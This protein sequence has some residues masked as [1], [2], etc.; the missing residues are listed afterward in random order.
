MSD[1]FPLPAP[2]TMPLSRNPQTLTLYGTEHVGKTDSVM[3]LPGKVLNVMLQRKGGDH[4]AGWF[5]DLHEMV[6]KGDF[7]DEA[8]TKQSY[9]EAFYRT[10]EWLGNENAAGRPVADFIVYDRIDR[11]EDWVFKRAL[12]TFRTT[13][14]GRSEKF[15]DLLRVTD[16]PG[17]G[18]QGSPGWNFVRE[19]MHRTVWGMQ[20]SGPRVVLICGMRDKFAF[21][22]TPKTMGDAAPND[23]DLTGSLRKLIC[24]DSSSFG[25]MYRNHDSDLMLNFRTSETTVCGTY[26]AHLRG[27]EFTL[28]K[29]DKKTGDTVCDWSQI[30]LPDAPPAVLQTQSTKTAP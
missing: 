8:R 2:R 10:L 6:D 15:N 9:D 23:L 20:R 19:E 11:M 18:N 27:K 21:S 17:Q 1:P 12:K 25:F 22:A 30:Y 16:I 3:R 26:C 4:L 13:V 29:V 28:G 7:G 5:M 24:N 14:I